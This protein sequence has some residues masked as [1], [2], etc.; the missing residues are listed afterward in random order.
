MAQFY[1]RARVG[2]ILSEKEGA[3]FASMEYLLCGLPVVSTPSIG[4]RDV[5]WDDRFVIVCDPTPEAVAGAVQEIKRRNIDP[6]LVRAATLEKVEEH[7]NVLR[8]FLPPEA[9]GFQCPWEPGSHGPTTFFNLR[10]L[11]K[12]LRTG[13]LLDLP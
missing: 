12:A 13:S 2:L 9:A 7:R 1:N 5:F 11:G 10:R 6:Q 4:G 3:C 8:R